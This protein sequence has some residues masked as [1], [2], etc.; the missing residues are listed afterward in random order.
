MSSFDRKLRLSIMG[1]PELVGN[2]SSGSV[3]PAVG[4]V[5]SG[6]VVR[7]VRSEFMH[8]CI[9]SKPFDLERTGPT[10]IGRKRRE[11]DLCTANGLCIM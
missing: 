7:Q 11:I 6:H 9:G 5:L 10:R 1:V 2:S 3:Y 8:R 4:E